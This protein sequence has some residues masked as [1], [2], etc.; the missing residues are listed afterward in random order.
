MALSPDGSRLYVVLQGGVE[1]SPQ[2]LVID[3]GTNLVTSRIPLETGFDFQIGLTADGT[4]A[5]VAVSQSSGNSNTAGQNRVDILIETNGESLGEIAF[6]E[7]TTWVLVVSTGS[8]ELLLVNIS[9]DD[10][11][12]A[13]VEGVVGV[14][15]APNDVF[16]PRQTEGATAYVSNTNDRTVSIVRL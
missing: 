13:S 14:G 8:D 2:V 10:L 11:T 12:Q 7:G 4:Y 6:V 16:V 9:A 15:Y 3:T 5:Y 1:A